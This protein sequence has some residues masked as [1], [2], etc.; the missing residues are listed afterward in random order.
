MASGATVV[1]RAVL[2][3]VVAALIAVA[4]FAF[5]GYVKV[6]QLPTPLGPLS[7]GPNSS[8]VGGPSN[9][10]ARDMYGPSTNLWQPFAASLH[11]YCCQ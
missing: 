7:F 6:T 4:F 10:H 8:F 1:T 5:S 11:S 3:L 2:L 9:A